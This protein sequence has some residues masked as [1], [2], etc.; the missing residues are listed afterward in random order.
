MTDNVFERFVTMMEK[1]GYS[2]SKILAEVR[3]LIGKAFQKN[4]EV[5]DEEQKVAK[6]L[7][8]FGIPTN[9]KGY[10]YLKE[11]IPAWKRNPNQKFVSELYSNVAEKFGTTATRVEHAIR[12]A[13]E[14]AYGEDRP[15]VS[16]FITI[17]AEKL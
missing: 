3:R 4:N 14:V 10:L 8:G 7:Q 1:D 9:I 11:A 12:H 5:P 15:T 17:A 16:R 2:E 6:L 13:L